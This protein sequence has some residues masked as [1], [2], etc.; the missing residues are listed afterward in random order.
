RLR[1]SL[2]ALTADS[3]LA[4]FY[5]P[6]VFFL[7]SIIFLLHPDSAW[8]LTRRTGVFAGTGKILEIA[9]SETTFVARDLRYLIP[10]LCYLLVAGLICTALTRIAITRRRRREDKLFFRTFYRAFWLMDAA[11]IIIISAYAVLAFAMPGASVDP[12][13]GKALKVFSLAASLGPGVILAFYAYRYNYLS[14][15]LWKR[16]LHIGAA[17]L[18]AVACLQGFN[19]AAGWFQNVLRVNLIIVEAGAVALIVALLGPA[20][21]L[22]QRLVHRVVTRKEDIH[23]MRLVEISEQLNAPSIFTL[24]QMFDFVAD[25]IRRAFDVSRV[26]L[27]AYRRSTLDR[28]NPDIHASNLRDANV[29]TGTILS[30]LGG[31]RRKYVDLLASRNPQL[32]DEIRALRCQLIFPLAR[33]GRITG[34]LGVG[35]SGAGAFGA[36]EIEMLSIFAG[37]VATAV[38]NLMLVDDKVNLRRKMLEGEKLLSLGRLSASVAHEVKNPLSAIKTITRVA[39]EDLPPESPIQG[40]LAMIHSEID[41]LNHVVNRLLDFARPSRTPGAAIDLGDVVDSVVTVL[42]H[43]ASRT[44]AQIDLD[45]DPELP[46]VRLDVDALKEILFNLILN[47]IQAVKGKGRVTVAASIVHEEG[48]EPRLQIT[49]ADTGPGIPP[50]D[51]DRVFEPFFTTKS[52]GTGLGLS[53]VRQKVADLGGKI[54]VRNDHGAR[55]TIR[56]PF[57]PVVPSKSKTVTRATPAGR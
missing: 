26:V 31:G 20:R 24:S 7:P 39:Q 41:R 47:G 29:K 21:G 19:A 3:A 30:F 11:M 52:A 38:E 17:L 27:L 14:L 22:V 37:H 49:V 32:I 34:L 23:R 57:T 12:F 36:A 5:L 55:F 16:P 35:K 9:N 50:E 43:E 1:A 4:L 13:T 10:Y 53:I 51:L 46:P 6:M 45:I 25:G 15:Q 8:L 2:L 28:P 18:A 33:G 48:E 54:S 56:I 42:R 44:K 40:D